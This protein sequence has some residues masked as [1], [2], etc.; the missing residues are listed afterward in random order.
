MCNK[1]VTITNPKT[2]K[3]VQAVVTDRIPR[4]YG[5]GGSQVDASLALTNAL[6]PDQND[7]LN[8]DEVIVSY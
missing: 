3:S 4:E 8:I 1:V 2:S 5:G 7:G 6:G